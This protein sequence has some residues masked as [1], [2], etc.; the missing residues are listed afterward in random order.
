VEFS[1]LF[2]LFF[3]GFYTEEIFMT[4]L[5]LYL[6]G[7]AALVLYLAA[8]STPSIEAPAAAAAPIE[9][10][11]SPSSGAPTPALVDPADREVIRAGEAIA[12]PEESL[13]SPLD[14]LRSYRADMLET[15]RAPEGLRSWLEATGRDFNASPVKTVVQPRWGFAR[16]H[17]FPDEP[18]AAR[19]LYSVWIERAA[20]EH[21]PLRDALLDL[22]RRE[23]E[24]EVWRHWVSLLALHDAPGD[25]PAIVGELRRLLVVLDRRAPDT[26]KRIGVI[27]AWLNLH[28]EFG[29]SA[30]ETLFALL[31]EPQIGRAVGD[32]LGAQ[33][34]GLCNRVT[35][36]EIAL[37]IPALFAHPSG[38]VQW[39]AVEL[40]RQYAARGQLSGEALVEMI[41]DALFRS[42]DGARCAAALELAAVFGGQNGRERL[43][44]IVRDPTSLRRDAAL[45]FLAV[46]G[47]IST[48]ETLQFARDRAMT[49]AVVD[50]LGTLARKG[51]ESAWAELRRFLS[52]ERGEIR[53][54]AA[55]FLASGGRLTAEELARI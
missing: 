46:G 23:E 40:L 11:W 24:F 20:G 26:P 47:L 36:R 39:G 35:Y 37:R 7:I 27:L 25:L 51:D 52:D 54:R 29:P 38:E 12:S 18:L 42:A 17:R 48:A 2:S 14:G 16:M 8:A 28:D 45:G 31:A 6:G 13:V 43:L 30:Q 5:L 49:V 4:R 34:C 9:A 22:V 10:V 44:G 41:P 15:A 21:L 1:F 3:V 33:L 53:R 55:A 19:S 50:A 32:Q